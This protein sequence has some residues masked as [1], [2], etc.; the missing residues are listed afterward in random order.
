[1]I[2]RIL[3]DYFVIFSIGLVFGVIIARYYY[4]RATNQS[5]GRIIEGV[6]ISETVDELFRQSKELES[7]ITKMR[8]ESDSLLDQIKRIRDIER[9]RDASGASDVIINDADSVDNNAVNDFDK[10]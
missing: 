10:E 1:M 7:L 5:L 9:S 3:E 4:E 8:S 2:W 6:M